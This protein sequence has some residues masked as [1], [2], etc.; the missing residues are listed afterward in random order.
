MAALVLG[1]AVACGKPTTHAGA[2]E[3][4]APVWVE[5]G[6]PARGADPP[7]AVQAGGDIP[8]DF[9]PVAVVRCREETRHIP[10]E[11]S[12]VVQVTERADTP[13]PELVDMLRKPSDPPPPADVAC[14]LELRTVPYFVLV[15][16]HGKALLPAVRRRRAASPARRCRTSWTP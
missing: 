13:V 5:A 6:C 1:A 9:T 3:P 10:G 14:T 8:A 15:D 4:P 7:R 16:A 12:W 2:P 11:G